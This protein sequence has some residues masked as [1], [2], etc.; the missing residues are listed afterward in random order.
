NTV[1][2]LQLPGEIL[3]MLRSGALSAGHA[4]ALLPLQD[5]KRQ[6]RL[7]RRVIERGGSVRSL[8][9]L[10]RRLAGAAAE[11]A[12]PKNNDRRASLERYEEKVGE[13]LGVE[14]VRLQ[15]D[16]KG[17][18]HLHVV[19]DTDTAWKRFITKIRK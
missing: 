3:D 12:E 1:R 5:P 10:V 16:V 17:R 14:G 8:E 2:L 13:L 19:F 9:E 7:A 6:V 18:R 4:R 11:P 15:L